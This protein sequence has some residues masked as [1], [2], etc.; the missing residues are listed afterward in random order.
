MVRTLH[1]LSYLARADFAGTLLLKV[2][3]RHVMSVPTDHGLAF[4]E[5]LRSCG[6]TPQQITL[7]LDADGL[8]DVDHFTRAVAAYRQ[9][10]YGIALSG[11]GRSSIDLSL[12]ARATT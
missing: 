2:N 6:L 12:G 10:G 3:R 8:E 9:R 7:E 4:E 1:A 5:I 11:F